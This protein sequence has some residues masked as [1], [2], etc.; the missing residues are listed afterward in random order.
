MP[1]KNPDINMLLQEMQEKIKQL[2][3]KLDE[4]D[5]LIKN[6]EG[7]LANHENIDKKKCDEDMVND[8]FDSINADK[9]KIKKVIRHKTRDTSKIPPVSIELDNASD[10]ISVLKAAYINR[11]KINEIFFNSDM[12]ESEK[13]LIKQLR[14]EVKLYTNATSL[15]NKFDL[16]LLEIAVYNP[17]IFIVTETWFKSSSAI[18]VSGYNVFYNNPSKSNST[19]PHGG[20]VAIYVKSEYIA[21]TPYD[22][23]SEE[24]TVEQVSSTLSRD[25]NYPNIK[26]NEND[27]NIQ[28]VLKNDRQAQIFLDNLN[29]NFLT[30]NVT[31]PTFNSGTLSEGN[32]LDLILT[33]A[34]ERISIIGYNP[35]LSNLNNAHQILPISLTSIPCKVLKSLIRDEILDYLINNSLLNENQHGFR[36][37]KSCTTNLSETLD[38]ITDALENDHSVNMLYLD[39][40]K[41]FD[42]VPHSRLITKHHSYGIVRN[43]LG[44]IENFLTNRKQ[45]VV[46]GDTVSDWLPVISGVPQGSVLGLLLFLIFI[47]ILPDQVKNPIKLYADDSKIIN[48]I[49]NPN[50]SISLQNDIN[51]IMT[52]SFIWLTKFNYEKCKV[53]HIGK[54]NPNAVFIM[55]DIDCNYNYTLCNTKAERDL[56]IMVQSDLKWHS[57]V[58]SATSKA[59]R[60]LGTIKRSFKYLDVNMVKMLYTTFIR[61]HLEFAV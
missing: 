32:T 50:D 27:E 3:K 56:G 22:L 33:D 51:N 35:P 29:D 54:K 48:V 11:N 52:W 7:R 57:Q 39:F 14:G 34:P 31:K 13:D 16:F 58:D 24:M 26:W 17:D 6:L 38:I 23:A 36:K 40:E 47:N 12:T 9:D 25:L 53:M 19:K 21:Y 43:Y 42:K 55:T 45:R 2:E 60:M 44:W 4:K 20:G 46:L 59:N 1:P 61:P 49:K 18:N 30:Q 41:A 5:V 15:N 8:I 10:K 28:T 37:N